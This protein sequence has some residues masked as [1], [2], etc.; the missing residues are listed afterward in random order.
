MKIA[1]WSVGWSSTVDGPGNR[2]VLY[3][4]GCPAKCPWCHSPH[5][6]YENSPLLLQ[7]SLC[8]FCGK[9]IEA[10]QNGAHRILNGKHTVD[11]QRCTAC[12]KCV[13]ACPYSG[14]DAA[15]SA[16]CLPT[17][18]QE[19]EEVFEMLRPQLD[20]VKSIGGITLSGGEALLQVDSAIELLKLCRN[21]G[22]HTCVETSM[23]LPEK[24]YGAASPYVDSWLLGFRKVY[25]PENI[26]DDTDIR[27]ECKRK[28]DLL[29]EKQGVRFIA[30]FPI[31]K[32]YTDTKEKMTLLRDILLEN[33]IKELELLPCNPHME[34][35]YRLMGKEV[36]VDVTRCIPS[37]QEISRI[38][39]NFRKAGIQ[40]RQV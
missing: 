5:S 16:L 39:E 37:K 18:R 7:E 38:T 17:V 11:Y 29:K 35:Y 20:I 34:H 1:Y 23:L 8:H 40:V 19:V 28:V 32:G 6:Q 4:Q 25:W 26:W 30:R 13:R 10:C 14:E 15:N 3:L 22:V 2:V 9:C 12:G 21:Y 36:F 31:I 33:E 24:V 27:W